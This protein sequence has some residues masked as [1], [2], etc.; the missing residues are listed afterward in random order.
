MYENIKLF[1]DIDSSNLPH[2]MGC[3]GSYEKDYDKDE[4]IVLA[5]E[6][7]ECIGIVLTGRVAI[8]KEDI[9]GRRHLKAKVGPKQEFAHSIV[10]SKA[11]ESPVT[12]I[13]EVKTRVLFLPYKKVLKTCSSACGFHHQLIDNLILS[14]ANSNMRMDRKIEYL[15][16]KTTHDKI[17]KYFGDLYRKTNKTIIEIPLNKTDLADFLVVERSVLSRELSK[18]KKEGIL[19]FDK[20]TF[21]LLDTDYF[22]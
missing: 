20:N 4:I 6:P 1:N 2:M 11:S 9:H 19:D 14:L 3:I 18:M 22:V 15:S 13:A 5:G 8:V 12:V 21:K 16:S 10:A 7:I 17:L